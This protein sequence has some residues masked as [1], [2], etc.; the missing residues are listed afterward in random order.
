M[1]CVAPS[2]QTDKWSL[3]RLVEADKQAVD[4]DAASLHR[5]PFQ[6]LV[7]EVGVD[8]MCRTDSLRAH[9]VTIRRHE[10]LESNATFIGRL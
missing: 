8:R 4:D 9:L 1:Y 3:L 6:L 7:A 10:Y 2:E 5:R